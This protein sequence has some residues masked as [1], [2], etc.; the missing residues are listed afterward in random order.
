M[1]CWVMCRHVSR[2]SLALDAMARESAQCSSE[3]WVAWLVCVK[4]AVNIIANMLL[5]SAFTIYSLSLFQR[6][7]IKNIVIMCNNFCDILII[8]VSFAE[9]MQQ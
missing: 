7:N 8:F 1:A 6:S 4:I 9:L 5:I 3:G 2:E